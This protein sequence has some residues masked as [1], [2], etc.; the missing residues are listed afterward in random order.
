MR[1]F[2]VG[3]SDAPS[4]GT[5]LLALRV[6]RAIELSA[7]VIVGLVDRLRNRIDILVSGRSQSARLRRS[8]V[9]RG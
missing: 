6:D 4:R 3:T 9:G 7:I 1:R 8:R 5:Y 2:R